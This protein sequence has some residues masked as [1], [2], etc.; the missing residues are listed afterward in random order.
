[1][2]TDYQKGLDAVGLAHKM[3]TQAAI[4][5]QA[6]HNE[7]LRQA[8]NAEAIPGL[9][10]EADDMAQ[11]LSIDSPTTITNNYAAESETK[12]KTRTGLGTLAKLAIG[13]GLIGTGAGVVPGI[14]LI[15]DGLKTTEK[16]AVI[17]PGKISDAVKYSL[18]LGD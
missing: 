7:E 8:V 3:A 12:T 10:G 14:G 18:D 4:A 5:K 6:N 2:P 13:A 11:T 16:P 9:T 17:V 1:M 15:L